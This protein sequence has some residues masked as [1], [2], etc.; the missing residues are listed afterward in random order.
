MSF[1]IKAIIF[2]L[3]V[4]V[5]AFFGVIFAQTPAVPLIFLNRRLYFRWCSAAMGYYLLMVTCLLEDLLGIKIIITGDD[6][7][8]DKKRSL[9]LLNHRTRLDWMFIWMV[10]SR[11]EILEQLKIVLKAQLKSLPGAGWAMQH[12]AYIFLDRNWEKDQQTIKNISGYYK[13][14]QVPLSILIFP[15]GTDLTDDAKIKS[16]AY[17]AQQTCFNR[18][19]DYCLHPR[20]TGFTYLL[21]TMRSDKVLDAVDD[22]TIGYEG[23]IPATEIDLIKG[24]I[25]KAIHFHVKRYFINDLPVSDDE[26]GYWLQNCWDEKENRLKEFY[27]T[28]QF[29]L[30]SKRL[31]N[32]QIESHIRSQRRL[33][34]I[35]WLLFILFWSYCILAFIK[36]KFY[37]CLVCFFHIIMDIFANGIIDFVCQLDMNYRDNEFKRT[38]SAIKQD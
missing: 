28:N 15:E 35:F 14:C 24:H 31:N 2:Y 33:A 8:K 21:N 9:I 16:N 30:P 17:A 7:T 37:V 27:L 3:F 11:F 10:H 23:N 29:D 13:S 1:T 26:V 36:M 22:V 6:L 32:E 4:T 38:Q 20:L 25:P 18:A 34:F 5:A 12:A 19:Y